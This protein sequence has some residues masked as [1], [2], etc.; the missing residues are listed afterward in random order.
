MDLGEASENT[1][2]H[3]LNQQSTSVHC[4]TVTPSLHC[5]NAGTPSSPRKPSQDLNGNYTEPLTYTTLS[6]LNF[7]SFYI[8]SCYCFVLLCKEKYLWG[9][10]KLHMWPQSPYF[11]FLIQPKIIISWFYLGGGHSGTLTSTGNKGFLFLCFYVLVITWVILQ[12]I[13]SKW[14]EFWNPGFE[15]SSATDDCDFGLTLSFS[16]LFH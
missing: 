9:L 3:D 8:M 10:S 11:F 1:K 7:H 14:K 15:S 6:H 16:L 12:S 2:T 5:H 4:F 13:L